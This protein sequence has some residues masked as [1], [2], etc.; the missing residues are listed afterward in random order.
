MVL[1]LARTHIKPRLVYFPFHSSFPFAANIERSTGMEVGM[2]RS[3]HFID[4]DKNNYRF[5]IIDVV[6]IYSTRMLFFILYHNF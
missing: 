3:S 4:V 1:R 2:G 5:Y 6:M